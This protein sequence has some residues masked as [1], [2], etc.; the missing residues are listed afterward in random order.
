MLLRELR[1]ENIRSYTTATV[2]FPEGITL[3]SG[4]IG[5]GKSTLLLALEFALFGTQRGELSG[6]ALLRH[7]ANRGSVSLRF[8]LENQEVEVTRSLKRGANS[9]LQE[10]GRLVCDGVAVE[11]SA[12]EL[13]A[14]ILELLNYPPGLLLK[15][16][17]PLW[18]YTV[19]TPQEEMKAILFEKPDDRLETLR[20]LFDIEKYRRVR[21]NTMVLIRELKREETVLVTRI[22]EL[23]HDPE[24]AAELEQR[25]KKL[26]AEERSLVEREAR[27]KEMLKREE[28]ELEALER[29]R[30]AQEEARRQR[31]VSQKT[32]E[33][34]ERRLAELREE[35]ARFSKTIE[36]PE[37][38]IDEERL[39]EKRRI[40]QAQAEKI[41]EKREAM[42]K[43]ESEVKLKLQEAEA[44]IARITSL[45]QCPTCEQPVDEQH[46][47]KIRRREEERIEK[48]KERLDSL[49]RFKEALGKKESQLRE[50]EE[51]FRKEEQA[52]ATYKVRLEAA[53]EREARRAALEKA[54]RAEEERLAAEK[55]RFAT[56]KEVIVDEERYAAVKGAVREAREAV[57]KVALALVAVRK[58]L[59]IA[60]RDLTKLRAEEEK[61][62]VLEEKLALL[63]RRLAWLQKQLLGVSYAIE[64]ALFMNVYALFNEYFTEWFSLLLEDES[65]SVR[66]N[67]E[68]SP[69][70]LQDGY[71]TSIQFLSGGEKTS[72]A[73]AY[74]LSLNK[75]INEFLSHIKTKELLI[76]DE[77]TDGFS[78]EQLDRLREVLDQLRL[79]QILLV[80]H[81]AQLEGCAD[82]V[83]R[84]VKEEYE[85][86]VVEE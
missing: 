71:E 59:E 1:L 73:L 13:K 61:R 19:Y 86:R 83:L 31:A 49:A 6:A 50:K 65:L 69:V 85:S 14:R 47:E 24:I 11:L 10:G 70:V 22:E 77:P 42:L 34:C 60:R 75:A 35:R 53:K 76:L 25:V 33:E 82:H 44:L 26:Q 29:A 20:K 18:R 66:L 45:T 8:L 48:A 43:Q 78:S 27:E 5:S 2:T 32:I 28:E 81:E 63:R 7:G 16:K 55:A 37:K 30:F 79:R 9:V 3:L 56:I 41:K 51:L 67:H 23:Q 17:R 74:R 84:V 80:S 64:K 36:L 57:K 12:Q 15:G 58:D 46:K 38:P 4:D 21:E 39:I 52:F 62:R 72:L 68:F 40:L 54:V